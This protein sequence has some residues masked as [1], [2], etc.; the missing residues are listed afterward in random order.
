MDDRSRGRTNAVRAKY[1][2][3][4]E[5]WPSTDIWH[6]YTSIRLQREIQEVTRHLDLRDKHVLN[7]GSG[8]NSYQLN[9]KTIVDVDIVDTKIARC[10][11]PI[12]ADAQE[13]PF[14]DGSFDFVLCVG[15]VLNYCDAIAACREIVRVLTPGGRLI[16]E[17]ESSASA[18]YIGLSQYRQ[19]S[20][21]VEASYQGQM[22]TIW[23]YSPKYVRSILGALR[24]F[25]VADRGFHTLTTL[26]YRLTANEKI[27]ICVSGLDQG[28]VIS[29]L[30]RPFA[31]NRVFLAQKE[32]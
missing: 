3:R 1:E 5:I 11:M 23:L 4:P 28:K 27:S 12:V 31:C 30:L 24:A 32:R 21:S 8:G 13:L 29:R 9:A 7:L 22:E 14:R 19:N 2:R 25:V 20:V 26:L 17:F 6:H 16:L 15:S 18:E 10:P